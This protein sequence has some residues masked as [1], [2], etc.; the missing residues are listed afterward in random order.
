MCSLVAYYFLFVVL[1]FQDAFV[2]IRF[3]HTESS[4]NPEMEKKFNQ[5]PLYL[6]KQ[7]INKVTNKQTSKK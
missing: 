3:H 2:N 5:S 7:L 6:Q 4:K 1:P